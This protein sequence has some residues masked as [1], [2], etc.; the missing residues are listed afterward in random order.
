MLCL[1]SSIDD[2]GHEWKVQR[3]QL[4]DEMDTFAHFSLDNIACETSISYIFFLT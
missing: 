1:P 4:N 2:L 3:I